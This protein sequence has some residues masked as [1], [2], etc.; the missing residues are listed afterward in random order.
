M[1]QIASLFGLSP[2]VAELAYQ[3]A[4]VLALLICI[5]SVLRHL[6]P[7]PI[8]P[9]VEVHTRK[10]KFLQSFLYRWYLAI[11]DFCVIWSKWA[12]PLTDPMTRSSI[13]GFL[14]SLGNVGE[15]E[16]DAGQAAGM[17]KD[18]DKT[19]VGDKAGG[20]VDMTKVDETV[21]PVSKPKVVEGE[22]APKPT[23]AVA[24]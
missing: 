2:D 18:M 20:V 24:Q 12:R 8:D 15:M 7:D 5:G 10:E 9:K 13:A 4:I 16:K 11:L 1:E 19:A 22:E 14:G 3:V 21:P 23:E 6:A 17:I